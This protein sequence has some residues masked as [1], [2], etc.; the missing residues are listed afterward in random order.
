MLGQPS[1]RHADKIVLSIHRINR[2]RR[3]YALRLDDAASVIVQG[4][5]VKILAGAQHYFS[6]TC[7]RPAG[8]DESRIANCIGRR[9]IEARNKITAGAKVPRRHRGRQRR[10]APCHPGI[11]VVIG[12][13]L[14]RKC[15]A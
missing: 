4:Y 12:L 5:V 10:A 14:K 6:D 3:V 8:N 2:P 1:Q 7:Y 13:H 11:I 9:G 15:I